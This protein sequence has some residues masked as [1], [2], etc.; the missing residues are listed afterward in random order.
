MLQPYRLSSVNEIIVILGTGLLGAFLSIGKRSSVLSSHAWMVLLGSAA[1]FAKAQ[2]IFFIFLKIGSVLF[3][4]G[5]VLFA[6][7]DGELIDQL[8]WLNTAQLTEA[9]AV[10]QMTPGPVLST[11]T[12]IGYQVGGFTGALSATIGIF[13]PAFFFVWLLN[14]IVHKMRSSVWLTGFLDYVNVAAVA[15]MLYVTFEMAQSVLT[16]FWLIALSMICLA[17][18][19]GLSKMSPFVIIAIGGIAGSVK[20]LLV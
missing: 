16:E 18:Y 17:L 10:G 20:Y 8:G 6:Y 4:S 11:A 9:V 3:G 2:K 15:V 14:P 19:F 5:Y 12:F 13:L 1:S 7:L